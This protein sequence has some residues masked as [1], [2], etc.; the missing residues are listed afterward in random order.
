MLIILALT[1]GI[2]TVQAKKS[3]KSSASSNTTAATN[4]NA[5]TDD[6]S[7]D[8][9]DQSTDAIDQSADTSDSSADTTDSSADVNTS[10]TGTATNT[11]ADTS[12]ATDTVAPED[13][14]EKEQPKTIAQLLADIQS[15]LAAITA[16]VQ[17]ASTA[18]Q[19]T[20]SNTSDL[21]K[22]VDAAPKKSILLNNDTYAQASSNAASA[23]GDLDDASTSLEFL[24]ADI[25]TTLKQAEKELKKTQHGG[26]GKS[27][28]G[29]KL[30]TVKIKKHK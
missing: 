21:A 15:E 14:L 3:S 26:S 29:S 1:M 13:A 23:A 2:N 6:S 10:A 11:P 22:L 12:G 9:I 16:K 7:T 24:E 18:A 28:K 17:A 30:K 25:A 5:A 19:A 20:I 8:A 27:K 4:S